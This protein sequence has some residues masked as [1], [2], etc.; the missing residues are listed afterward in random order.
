MP[1]RNAAA[2]IGAAVY[3]TL[4]ALPDDGLLIV[5]DD[6]STDGTADV[7]R[8]I[9]DRRLSVLVGDP[10][11]IARSANALLD[12]VDT[13]FMCRMDADD[14][15]LPWR[16]RAQRSVL[17]SADLAFSPWLRWRSGTALVKPA[18]TRRLDGDVARLELLVENPFL[19]SSMIGRTGSIR[20]IGA[21]R[22]VASEDY[23][24]WLRAAT[25]GLRL[26]RSGPPVVLYRRHPRQTSQ[27]SAWLAQRSASTL[28]L[29]AWSV[30]AKQLLGIVPG[31]FTW[32][33]DGFPANA[34]PPDVSADIARMR[35]TVLDAS[36]S[37]A[38]EV[39]ACLRR[40]ERRAGSAAT[41]STQ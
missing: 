33:R 39:L 19:H 17:D 21:Y 27:Q 35:A 23:D 37:G 12:A 36:G 34:V 41:S 14:I 18:M 16:F 11:G 6:G 30:L 29:D 7:L 2:T 25:A 28:V 4:R 31:W 13:P 22:D 26:R 38:A 10:I 15:C 32:R 20:A 8:R 1:A 9:R 24:L 40:M 5:R 3:S